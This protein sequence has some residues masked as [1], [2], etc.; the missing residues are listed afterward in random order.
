MF[1]VVIGLGQEIEVESA[2]RPVLERHL[3]QWN[4]KESVTIIGGFGD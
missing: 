1:D 3:D 4:R 2:G